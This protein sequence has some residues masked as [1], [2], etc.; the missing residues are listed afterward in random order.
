MCNLAD[1][2]RIK[3]AR[4]LPGSIQSVGE[5]LGVAGYQ[6][7]ALDALL[8]RFPLAGRRV[9][10]VGGSN[11]PRA[12]VL[13]HL[14]A[15]EWVAI[16]VIAP[17]SY[18]LGRQPDHYAREGIHELA[19]AGPLLGTRPYLIL[20]GAIEH[21]SAL[22]ARYFDAVVS[23]ASFEHILAMPSALATMRR[24]K[25]PEAPIFSYHGPVWSSYCGHH[26]EVDDEL[27][28]DSPPAVPPFGHLLHGPPEMHELLAARFG[29]AR[30]ERAVLQMYHSPRVNRL[31]YEDYLRYFARAGFT[32]V[33]TQAYC[34]IQ[35]S[36][37]L[38]RRLEARHPGHHIFD[39]YGM[40]VLAH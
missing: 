14:G 28:F 26:I 27:H 9:L 12:L 3:G 35:V 7:A 38:Q 16:D 20:N 21:A 5:A 24:L 8:D 30:A 17:D 31:F 23:I 13:D 40:I 19:A 36:D 33:E 22:P 32:S 37:D 15:A 39:A 6:I 29:A 1:L 2:E 18:Q 25:R 11:L 34:A 10:E 4:P